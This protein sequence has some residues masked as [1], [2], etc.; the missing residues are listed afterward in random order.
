MEP[1]ELAVRVLRVAG[2]I[3]VV[4]GAASCKDRVRFAERDVQIAAEPVV[5]HFP[6]PYRAE[7]PTR[8]LCLEPATKRDA[9]A[10]APDGASTRATPV[11]AI[12]IGSSG[13]RD[14]LGH[15]GD[16]SWMGRVSVWSPPSIDMLGG[17]VCLWDHGLSNPGN[18]KLRRT[19]YDSAGQVL[20]TLPPEHP[21]PPLTATYVGVELRSTVPA[22]IREATF[23][24]GQRI[25]FP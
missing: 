9:R 14:T 16:P 20:A 22:R 10:I 11:L 19:V 6:R 4:A 15:V 18:E 23:W 13:E 25:A 7:G 17:A 12:M 24:S 21:L 8:E 3:L 5:L 2:I 1:K